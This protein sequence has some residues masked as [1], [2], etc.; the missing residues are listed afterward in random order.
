MSRG[1]LYISAEEAADSK[2]AKKIVKARIGPRARITSCTPNRS[3]GGWTYCYEAP[4]AEEDATAKAADLSRAAAAKVAALARAEAIIF[5][6]VKA[7][8][9]K[10]EK[11]DIPAVATKAVNFVCPKGLARRECSTCGEYSP[12]MKKAWEMAM[13]AAL[14]PAE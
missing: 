2:A 14:N 4:D 9:V 11:P 5:G 12:C 6:D 3:R 7:F 1:Q 10:V 13:S 8:A